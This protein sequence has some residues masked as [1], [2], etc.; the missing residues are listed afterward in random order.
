MHTRAQELIRTLG[1]EPHREGG[2]FREMFRS[3]DVVA[4]GDARGS[5]PAV[6]TIYFLLVEGA[7]S[8]WHRVLSDEVWHLYEGAPLELMEIDESIGALTRHRLAP[9]GDGDGAPVYTIPRRN[10]QA[11]RSLGSYTLV[12][13]TVGPGFDYADFRMM[14]DDAETAAKVRARWP[15]TAAALI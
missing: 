1:L 4:P 2:F 14:S 15:E 9:V 12:G 5:R 3:T 8:R 11:A 10:W 7:H 13:C 6:T